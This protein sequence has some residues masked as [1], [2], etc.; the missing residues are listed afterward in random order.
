[1]NVLLATPYDFSAT[2]G[3]TVVVQTIGER[4]MRAGH[5]AVFLVPQYGG[6]LKREEV[7]GIPLY[8]VPMR[9]P[10]V[11]AHPLRS[12]AAFLLH[13][14]ATLRAL[15]KILREERIE[16]VN[17]HYFDRVWLYFF[18]LRRRLQFA[19]VVSVHGS[20]VLGKLGAQNVEYLERR[21][22]SID[23]VVY[24]SDGF[25]RQVTSESSPLWMK[26][27]PILN[28]IDTSGLPEAKAPSADYITSVAH[29]REHKGQDTLLRAFAMIKDDFPHLGLRIVGEGPFRPELERVAKELGLGQRVELSGDVP[30]EKALEIIG[31][32]RVFCLPSRRE[33]FGLVVL[34]A[35]ALGVPVVA[36]N[37]GGVPEIL[38]RNT[39][40]WLVE[41]D[42]PREMSA[43]LKDALTNLEKRREHVQSAKERVKD[44]FSVDRFF[45]D[46]QRLYQEVAATASRK[47]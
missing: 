43:A 9:E 23:R 10:V 25:R 24:C 29:L 11:A 37:V 2:G 34:E 20:D 39:D 22:D 15:A 19:F 31:G 30:R 38:R 42:S 33:P 8:R 16:V 5:R 4:L 28:G 14:P 40:A 18:L 44:Y 27:V 12:R 32:A 26:S 41:A 3:V 17:V 45:S 1:M 47:G 35:M 13:L 36:T 21:V 6:T 46:Y 7:D